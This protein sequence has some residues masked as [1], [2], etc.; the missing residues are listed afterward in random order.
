MDGKEK[1]IVALLFALLA[2]GLTWTYYGPNIQGYIAGASVIGVYFID[3]PPAGRHEQ[4]NYDYILM[5]VSKFVWVQVEEGGEAV[6]TRDV[7]ISLKLSA[8]GL[9][10]VK[11]YDDLFVAEGKYRALHIYV[12]N[13]TAYDDDDELVLYFNRTLP[14]KIVFKEPVELVGGKEY[15]L[16]IDIYCTVGKGEKVVVTEHNVLGVIHA[17]A[18]I[19]DPSTGVNVAEGVSSG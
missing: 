4:L 1:T 15:N 19:E 9:E 12:R 18:T 5:D 10:P 3:P 8:N 17:T 6:V 16:Y 11:G 13:I 2:L 7:D 14:I